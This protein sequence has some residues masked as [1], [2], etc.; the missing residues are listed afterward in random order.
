MNYKEL[1]RGSVAT[2]VE[3]SN[4]YIQLNKWMFRLNLNGNTLLVFAAIHSFCRDGSSVYSGSIGYLSE[5]LNVSRNTIIKALKDLTSTK[6]I[7]KIDNFEG[8]LSLPRYKTNKEV[9]IDKLIGSAEIARVQKLHT[10]YAETDMDGSAETAHHNNTSDKNSCKNKSILSEN[11]NLSNEGLATTLQTQD[12]KEKSCAKKESP[13]RA[14]FTPPNVA[15]VETYCKERNNGIDANYFVDYYTS[16]GWMVGRTKMKDW[17][18][19]VRNW[20]RNTSKTTNKQQSN[21]RISK[22]SSSEIISAPQGYAYDP[23]SH[24]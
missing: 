17:K 9:I 12:P 19:A 16:N 18:A 2:I 24:F 13:K 6:L 1:T 11:E 23:T 3:E 15:E 4:N 5:T 14:V 7:I 21:G 8:K 20:E 22:A 10:P